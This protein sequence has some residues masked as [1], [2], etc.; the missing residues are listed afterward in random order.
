MHV[1]TRFTAIALLENISRC[2][3]LV[4]VFL[5]EL[6]TTPCVWAKKG[7]IW[8]MNDIKGD[9]CYWIWINLFQGTRSQEIPGKYPTLVPSR[10]VKCQLCDFQRIQLKLF[11]M[12]KL[13]SK[14]VK[15]APLLCNFIR[16]DLSDVSHSLPQYC[17]DLTNSGMKLRR[18][19]QKQFPE[20]SRYNTHQWW[21]TMH[22]ASTH[23]FLNCKLSYHLFIVHKPPG[24]AVTHWSLIRCPN[25][26]NPQ[27]NI[28]P[29][30][31]SR[32]LKTTEL[33]P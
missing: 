3:K 27:S 8:A 25:R 13:V 31:L 9:W 4:F 22:V 20:P 24:N 15:E 23:Y 2:H 11:R 10:N 14:I 21:R 1:D 26:L 16:A 12:W 18:M 29:I 17:H 6:I 33:L 5:W 32:S 19:S 28:F 30:S 7:T